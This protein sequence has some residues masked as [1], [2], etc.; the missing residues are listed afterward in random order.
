MFVR[1]A[2]VEDAAAIA[3]IQRSVWTQDYR[4]LM[5]VAI[6]FPE[7]DQLTEGWAQAIRTA[8][9]ARSRVFVATENE[10]VVGFAAISEVDATTDEI[11]SLH[12]AKDH[13]RSGHATRLLTAIAETSQSMGVTTLSTWALEGDHPWTG[14]LH[15]SGF[16][17]VKDQR[18]LDHHGDGALVLSQHRWQTVLSDSESKS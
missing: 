5:R 8:P 9:S 6:D 11:D 16:G 18:T 12:V 7:V 4:P 1:P 15:A 2:R 14:L 10:A 13:R 17:L 3:A